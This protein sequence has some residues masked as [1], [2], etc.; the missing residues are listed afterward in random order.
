MA[1]LGERQE[2]LLMYLFRRETTD[3]TTDSYKTLNREVTKKQLER[4]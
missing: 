2:K 1:H 4:Q 3:R